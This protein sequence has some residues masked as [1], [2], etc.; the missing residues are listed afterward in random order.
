[1]PCMEDDVIACCGGRCVLGCDTVYSNGQ[2][3]KYT[4]ILSVTS[5]ETQISPS[6]PSQEPPMLLH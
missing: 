3:L 6:P 1:V 4:L 2:V 5:V